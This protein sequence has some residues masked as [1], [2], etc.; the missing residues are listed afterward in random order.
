[1]LLF[2]VKVAPRERVPGEASSRPLVD[3]EPSR[4]GGG[5]TVVR[6]L[7]ISQ[8]CSLAV[9]RS[10]TVVQTVGYSALGNDHR[11]CSVCRRHTPG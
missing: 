1:M 4:A 3:N 6:P 5:V 11:K 8:P 9:R 7:T 10:H 2:N